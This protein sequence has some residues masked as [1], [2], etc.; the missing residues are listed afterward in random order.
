MRVAI[1]QPTYLPWIGYFSLMDRVDHFVILDSVQFDRRSWQQRNRIKTASDIQMLTIPALTKGKRDQLICEVEIDQQSRF[2]S[3][4]QNAIKFA[5]AAAPFYDQYSDLIFNALGKDTPLLAELT[6]GLIRELRDLLGITTEISKSSEMDIQGSK[7]DLLANICEK[8][9]A[10]EYVSPPGSRAYMDA[11]TAFSDRGI[12]VRYH[13]YEHPV[14]TQ[15][16]GGFEPFM[17][18]IDLLFNAG[19]DSLKILRKGN[20]IQSD[21]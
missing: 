19:E 4:H 14:Y 16:H 1:M 11:S 9:D 17:S 10:T 21:I 6:I 12:A 18:T 8:L 13:E 2:K 5:Y 15:M 7:A 20:S 3:K